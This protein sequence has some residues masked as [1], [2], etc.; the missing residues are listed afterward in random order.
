MRIRT[1]HGHDDWTLNVPSEAS[2]STIRGELVTGGPASPA[3]T[4]QYKSETPDAMKRANH[5][6]YVALGRGRAA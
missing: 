4:L 5:A 3:P 2:S 6:R 1:G